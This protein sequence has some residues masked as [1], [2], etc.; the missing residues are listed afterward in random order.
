MKQH[1]YLIILLS[2][3]LFITACGKSNKAAQENAKK[4]RPSD[5]V[6]SMEKTPCFG[7]CPSYKIEILEDGR[8]VYTG[9]RHTERKDIWERQLS[10]DERNLLWQEIQRTGYL[11][12]QNV[13]DDPSLSDAPSVFLSVTANGS[14]HKVQDRV[15]APEALKQLET[16]LDTLADQPG[17]IFVKTYTE[18][19]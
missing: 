18:E 13:Y 12:M 6:M 3:F 11:K 2:S 16:F 10:D 1:L 7:T 15:N 5:L 4:G 19:N 14:T 17:L 9:I 8:L